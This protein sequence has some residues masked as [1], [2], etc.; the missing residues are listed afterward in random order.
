VIL[1]VVDGIKAKQD[2]EKRGRERKRGIWISKGVKNS[3]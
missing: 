3:Q 2:R 1:L